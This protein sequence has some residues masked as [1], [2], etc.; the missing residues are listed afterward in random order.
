MYQAVV[1]LLGW[2]PCHARNDED[3]VIDQGFPKGIPENYCAGPAAHIRSS[4]TAI[5]SLSCARARL[6]AFTM[7]S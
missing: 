7:A 4:S 6:E 5:S 1:L 3:S 2:P